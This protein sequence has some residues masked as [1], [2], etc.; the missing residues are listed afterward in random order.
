M[1]CYREGVQPQRNILG[2]RR[3]NQTSKAIFF[4]CLSFFV[5]IFRPV[6][7][8]LTFTA[9]DGSVINPSHSASN[10]GVIFDNN[11]NMERQVAA[12]CESAFLHMR[13]ISCIRKFL[14]AGSTK[15]LTHAFVMCRLDNCNSLLYQLFQSCATC[16]ILCGFKYDCITPLLRYYTGFRGAEDCFQNPTVDF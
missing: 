1:K 12:I 13:N 15:M 2:G 5:L 7:Q 10:I 6:S 4:S 16:L 8:L 9:V 3:N 14:S 11:L